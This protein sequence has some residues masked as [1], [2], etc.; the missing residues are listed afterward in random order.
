MEMTGHSYSSVNGW[1]GQEAR[2]SSLRRGLPSLIGRWITHRGPSPSFWF[3]A[4]KT[5][6][7]SSLWERGRANRRRRRGRDAP[8]AGD[9]W[10]VPGAVR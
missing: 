2:R 4:Q 3:G 9:S 6:G 5:L 1:L 8:D 7:N 10:P